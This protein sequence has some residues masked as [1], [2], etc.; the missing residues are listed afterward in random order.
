MVRGYVIL[1]FVTCR[2]ITMHLYLTQF[3]RAVPNAL[4]SR[5]IGAQ[6][7]ESTLAVYLS[8]SADAGHGRV[9]SSSPHLQFT[10]TRTLLYHPFRNSF[11]LFSMR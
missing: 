2:F 4:T 5:Y 7:S 8:K 6:R 9:T 1:S 3:T 10:L 11:C